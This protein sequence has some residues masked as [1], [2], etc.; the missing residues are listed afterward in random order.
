ME[1]DTGNYNSILGYILGLYWVNGK[2]NGNCMLGDETSSVILRSIPRAGQA[3]AEE[4]AKAEDIPFR[5]QALGVRDL[6]R[7]FGVWGLRF[8]V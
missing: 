2:E 6:G 4:L 3:L 7:G 5:A 8:R 1:K